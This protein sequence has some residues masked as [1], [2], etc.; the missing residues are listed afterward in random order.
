MGGK[1]KE[2]ER[3]ERGSEGER[4]SLRTW[5]T[6]SSEAALPKYLSCGTDQTHA[7]ISRIKPN[8]LPHQDAGTPGLRN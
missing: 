8:S 1:G 3:R 2:K 6:F 7:I 5:G 4:A